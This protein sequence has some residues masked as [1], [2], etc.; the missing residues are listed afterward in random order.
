MN[1]DRYVRWLKEEEYPVYEMAGTY[2]RQYQ[3]ALV[4]ACPKPEPIEI[5]QEQAQ[6]LLDRSG[7]LF[8]RYFSRTVKYPTAFWYTVCR[9]YDFQKLA[10]K[11]RTH[12]RRAYKSCRVERVDPAWLANNGFP[13]YVAAFSRYRNS[14][15]ESRAKFEEMCQSTPGGPFEFWGAF[16]D[17]RL[18]GFAKSAVGQDYA[19]TFVLKLDPNYMQLSTG[20]ALQDTILKNY[21]ADQGKP[22]YAGFRSVVHDTNTHDFLLQLG[23]TRV[24]CDLKVVYRPAVKA[25]VNLLYRW[26]SLLDR[27]PESAVKRNIRGVLTQEE[28]RR[29]I[30]ADGKHLTHPSIGE[31][32]ARSVWGNRY[33]TTGK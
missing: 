16:V 32:V 27:V 9:E 17:Q 31:R 13:C 18:V 8:L 1:M 2:W 25:C 19:A 22:V 28:I 15:P 30:E 20:P 33:G 7:A 29:S 26:R 12:I 5:R 10:Q 23:Y 14:E 4:P 24:Y 6:E 21:V 11:V 3:N